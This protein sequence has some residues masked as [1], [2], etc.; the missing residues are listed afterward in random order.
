LKDAAT[1]NGM[2]LI[3]LGESSGSRLPDTM[4]AQAMAQGGLDPQQYC[5]RREIPWISAVLG[6][7]LGS[8]TWYSCLSDFVVMRK[9]ASLAVSSPR[10]TSIAIGQETDLEELG[11]WRLHAEQTGLIDMAVD[12]DEQAIAA[13]RQFIG[14]LPAHAGEAPPRRTIG[15]DDEPDAELLLKAI[16]VEGNK[17]YDMRK[18]IPHIVDKD[19][20]FPLKDRF[21]RAVV[22]GLARLNGES[23]GII[24]SNPFFKAGAMDPDAC[25][26]AT[27][28]MVLCD[29]F[30][31][32][33]LFLVDTPGFLIGVDGER[34][35]A[36]AHI[37]NMIHALQ[38]CTVPKVSLILRKSYGQAYL[39]MGGGRNADDVAIWA[40]AQVG[41]MD[42]GVAA[43]VL[44]G[45][46]REGES[47]ESLEQKKAEL[48]RDSS[49]YALAAA[50]GVQTV[51]EPR[52]TR[53]YLIEAFA[54]QVRARTGGIG[55]HEMRNWPTYI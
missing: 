21:G 44:Y 55:Q 37:M 52:A 46:A 43:N 13:I 16:P 18:A 11:G 50:F 32:P 51:I 1:R 2:P 26:K 54:N 24:A 17:V 8:S 19:S 27:S 47:A 30:N 3:F 10:V 45:T 33:L 31:I 34:K 29:S 22:T 12:T 36:P 38:L 4:G 5:R 25:R 41:F 53:Q 28:F 35:G 15:A 14:Y 40:G 6:P 42:P 9:G 49:A 39:N 20:F 7:C 23:I 48:K